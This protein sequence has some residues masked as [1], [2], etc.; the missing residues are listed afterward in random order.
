[1]VKGPYNLISRQSLECLYPKEFGAFKNVTS[2]NLF[3]Q[4]KTSNHGIHQ[5]NHKSK[6]NENNVYVIPQM[7][8]RKVLPRINKTTIIMSDNI[9]EDKGCF[10][11]FPAK[12]WQ[13]RKPT[14]QW[15]K[16]LICK[17][18]C[19]IQREKKLLL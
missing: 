8:K 18:F 10:H 16:E 9:S 17:T 11:T 1:M 19:C 12:T 3:K 6:N 13:Q 7:M 14:P 2:S 5:Y 4:S 15:A